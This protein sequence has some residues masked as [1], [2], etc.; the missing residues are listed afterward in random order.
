MVKAEGGVCVRIY[1]HDRA[2]AGSVAADANVPLLR[3]DLGRGRAGLGGGGGAGIPGV[4][5][6]C[7]DIG[8][9]TNGE[10]RPLG[11]Y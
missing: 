11:R 10:G 8:R 9:N 5:V 6:E 3:V 2:R 1:G 7:G 4:A